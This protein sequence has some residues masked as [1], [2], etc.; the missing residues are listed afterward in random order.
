ME[1]KVALY[2]QGVTM[3]SLTHAQEHRSIWKLH[4]HV[5]VC[6]KIIGL[7]K[8]CELSL[9]G[10]SSIMNYVFM[11]CLFEYH[12]PICK[13]K[14]NNHYI[15][16][17]AWLGSVTACENRHEYDWE[18]QGWADAPN[19]VHSLHNTAGCQDNRLWMT[20]NCFKTCSQ[21]DIAGKMWFPA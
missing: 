17:W 12:L 9:R 18:C 1:E 7:L 15:M 3:R 13:S 20:E 4:T 19:R 11:W 16:N 14:E 21:C 2:L 5:N 6:V 8:L 10:A